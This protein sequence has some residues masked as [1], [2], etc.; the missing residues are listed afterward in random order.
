MCSFCSRKPVWPGMN[1]CG[2]TC[3]NLAKSGTSFRTSA[4]EGGG[5]GP[6]IVR[7]TDTEKGQGV[8]KQFLEKWEHPPNINK[9][10]PTESSIVD[11]FEITPGHKVSSAFRDYQQF[12][13]DRRNDVSSFSL[14]LSLYIY[15]CVCVCVVCRHV[16]SRVL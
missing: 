1:F 14:S 16:T 13:D 15:V 10:K 11:I 8:L 9:P 4:S 3:A 7:V 2:K 6:G 5:D 12:L